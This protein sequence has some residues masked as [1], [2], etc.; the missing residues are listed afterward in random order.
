MASLRVNAAGFLES[1]LGITNNALLC[2]ELVNSRKAERGC[3]E[4]VFFK[5]PLKS[6]G[7]R[8]FVRCV[9]VIS[10]ETS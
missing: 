1:L 5:G 2:S 10:T 4:K 9:D 6:L 8:S 7:T 3:K